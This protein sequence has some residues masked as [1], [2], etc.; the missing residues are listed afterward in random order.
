[1]RRRVAVP[2]ATSC[3]GFGQPIIY[4]SGFETIWKLGIVVVIGYILIGTRMAV[5]KQRPPLDWKE[6]GDAERHV[7][8]HR[9]GDAVGGSSR[10]HMVRPAAVRPARLPIGSAM[11]AGL[12]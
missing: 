4:F 9:C 7:G 12:A 6:G 5:D 3:R 10:G 1:M 11:F 8:A 2:W